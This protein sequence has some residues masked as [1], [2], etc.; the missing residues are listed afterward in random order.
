MIIQ[1]ILGFT[2]INA[3]IIDES[4]YC[5]EELYY[6]I[7][8]RM[9]GENIKQGKIRLISSPSSN[10]KFRWFRDLCKRPDVKVIHA[11]TFDNPFTSREYKLSQVLKYGEGT[12]MFRQQCLGEFLDTE[13]D[14]AVV[15]NRD[16]PTIK[17]FGF[18]IR[19]M[20]IDCAGSGA[21]DNV[22]T[23]VDNTGILDKVKVNKGDTFQLHTVAKNLITKWNIREVR[24]DITGG[25]GNGLM[26]MLKMSSPDV[27]VI[28]INFG[29]KAVEECYG[30]ARSE[31]YFNMAE[32]IRNGFY[33]EDPEIREELT[34]T[35]YFINQSGKT[36]L[37]P[38]VKIKEQ[39]GRS[40]DNADSLGLALYD[41]SDELTEAENYQ[42]AMKYL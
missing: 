3:A 15:L 17:Q 21:D 31:L 23:V 2:D 37:T 42:I 39:L 14:F 13:V 5:P 38:K 32:K 6:Y 4:A 33:V 18:G 40:P 16:F 34:S 41:K 24:I 28:G 19:K 11:T 30:N 26:D 25:F 29:Q 27:K 8:D 22:F 1:N 7:T 36:M 9:R 35:T 12:P 10:V 20:G